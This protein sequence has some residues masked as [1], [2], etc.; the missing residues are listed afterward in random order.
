[1][2]QL[3]PRTTVSL[4]SKLVFIV[5]F[6]LLSGC[7]EESPV[8]NDYGKEDF[9]K[10]WNTTNSY[11]PF[12]H[13]KNLDWD[14]I[15]TNY[16]AQFTD[17][18]DAD[19]VSLLGQLLNELKD[20][21]ANLFAINGQPLSVYS[22]PRSVKDANSFRLEVVRL[23]FSSDLLETSEVFRYGI[24]S[25]NIGYIHISSFPQ[26]EYKYD[27]FDEVLSTLMDTEGL[28]IDIRHNG[29]GSTNASEYFITHL[30]DEELEGTLWTDREGVYRP[31]KY[32]QPDRGNLYIK[33]SA[34]LVN[35]KSFSTAESMA[36]L[37][38]KIDHI[39]LIGDTTGGGGGIPDELFFLPS[40]CK[41]RVPTRYALR[42][43]G[44]H[45]EWNGI[46]PDIYIPQTKE[47]IEN[48]QDIQLEYA[49]NYLRAKLVP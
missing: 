18:S 24:L 41:F 20:G 11:Y 37:C 31:L 26:E 27:K 43:D 12:F 5:V 19:R 32:Y 36:N 10:L 6:S 9:E 30:I 22:P 33:K 8:L 40:G 29:G 16:Q 21:H 34:L 46:P 28:I 15:Y 47:D 25:G 7:K 45:I 39:T 3:K 44:E 38:K 13:Y 17:I 35:G 48:L 1:M 23:Y 2:T 14:S 4:L 49:I 42:Y